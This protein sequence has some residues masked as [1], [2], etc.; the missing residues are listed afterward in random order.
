M[1]EYLLK[2]FEELK[3]DE[4]KLLAFFVR[5]TNFGAIKEIPIARKEIEI[6]GEV[7]FRYYDESEKVL[8]EKGFIVKN[9]KKI[10]GRIRNVFSIKM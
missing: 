7:N 1:F 8:V 9:Q 5:K 6:S 4:R 3:Q 10:D 2:L